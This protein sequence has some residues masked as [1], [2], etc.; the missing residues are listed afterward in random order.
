MVGDEEDVLTLS[1]KSLSINEESP[2]LEIADT[3]TSTSTST[4]QPISIFRLLCVCMWTF[5]VTFGFNA[6]FV[7]GTPMFISLGYL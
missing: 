4:P 5:G 7:L 6:E 2:L 1:Q 3:S